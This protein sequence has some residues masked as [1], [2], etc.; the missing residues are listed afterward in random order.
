VAGATGRL[1]DPNHANRPPPPS[2][3]ET[4]ISE[5]HADRTGPLVT[6]R[7]K[8]GSFA[9]EEAAPQAGAEAVRS[10]A[11]RAANVPGR[12]CGERPGQADHGSAGERRYE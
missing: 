3:A 6:S 4:S 10:Q 9:G 2:F 8:V 1:S 11:G 7:R 5:R 12:A